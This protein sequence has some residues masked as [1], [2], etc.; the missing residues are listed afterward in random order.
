MSIKDKNIAII[1]ADGFEKS[2]Y[3]IPKEALEKAGARTKTISLEKGEVKSW[4]NKNWGAT[5]SADLGIAD[6]RPEIFDALVLPGGVMNPDTLRQNS[7]VLDFVRAMYND[8]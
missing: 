2:E 3:V 1:V 8:G 5:I 4:F 6:A 7:Q